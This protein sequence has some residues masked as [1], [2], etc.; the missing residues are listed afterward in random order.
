MER[1]FFARAAMR[2]IGHTT[3]ATLRLISLVMPAGA[4]RRGAPVPQTPELDRTGILVNSAE[5][6]KVVWRDEKVIFPLYDSSLAHSFW[7]AQEFSLFMQNKS[8]LMPPI[9]D[10]GCGDGSFAAVL[11]TRID[12]GS[13]IDEEAL[14]IARN[15]NIYENLIHSMDTQIPL[16]DGVI[17]SAIS[18]SVLEHVRDLNA[19]MGELSRVIAP[20]GVLMFSVP[21]R[22]FARDLQVFF[23]RVESEQ[24]NA[25][26]YHRNLLEV[27][28][29]QSLL[30]KN[31]FSVVSI[32]HFQPD[33]F[34][35]Y[36]WMLRFLG[37]RGLGRFIP[38]IR[39]RVWRVRGNQLVGMVRRSISETAKLGGNIFVIAKKTG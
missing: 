36:Y 19:V 3:V 1:S 38:S 12:Y 16:P 35:F 9:L 26:F 22:Q 7:R 2:V 20:N 24:V 34:S 18:N 17:N 5:P 4:V 31:G 28:E 39:E 14:K 32:R 23:G 13:D 11:F 29:W 33:W 8:T 10:L 25:D 15:F 30:T 21:V 6:L 27:E 37:R